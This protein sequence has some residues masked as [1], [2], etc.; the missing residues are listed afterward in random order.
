MSCDFI[1]ILSKYSEIS[2]SS[3]GKSREKVL[4]E[5]LSLL[6]SSPVEKQIENHSPENELIYCLCYVI[7]GVVKQVKNEKR[8]LTKEENDTIY[9]GLLDVVLNGLSES[10]PEYMNPRIVFHYENPP[11][12]SSVSCD[13]SPELIG[14]CVSAIEKIL[15]LDEFKTDQTMEIVYLHYI[16]ALVY[17]RENLLS[18]CEGIISK[19]KVMK[20]LLL[21]KSIQ[22]LPK[23]ISQVLHQELM[24]QLYESGGFHSLATNI[25]LTSETNSPLWKKCETL[26]RI[27]A[28]PGHGTNFYPFIVQ[29]VEACARDSLE[30]N[31]DNL[32]EAS[33]TCL[34][35]LHGA[36]VRGLREIVENV[37]IGD[38]LKLS[39]PEDTLTGVI[40]MDNNNLSSVLKLN[41]TAFS[42]SVSGAKSKILVKV[43]PLLF[44]LHAKF[45]DNS[46]PQEILQDLI[47]KCLSNRSDEEVSKLLEIFLFGEDH[48]NLCRLHPR[49][50]VRESSS[51]EF[52][53]QMG[54]EDNQNI[55]TV[56]NLTGILKKSN[57]NLLTY[58]IFRELLKLFQ[59]CLHEK[60]Q[61][62]KLDLLDPDDVTQVIQDTFQKR[63]IL[64]LTL[65]ELINFQPIHFLLKEHPQDIVPFVL[66]TIR[67]EANKNNSEEIDTEVIIIL[68]SIFRE[69]V[70]VEKVGTF[71]EELQKLLRK[72]RDKSSHDIQVYI[73][74][75]LCEILEEPRKFLEKSK[76]QEVRQL[77]DEKMPHVR[78]YGMSEMIKLIQQ[79]DVETMA[80]LHSTFHLALQYLTD[81]DSYSF[82][83]CIRLIVLLT[84]NLN[85]VAIDT[86]VHE[87][88]NP[89]KDMD[90]KLKIGEAIVKI[91]EGLGPVAY[92]YKEVLINCYL[93]G[94]KSLNNIFRTSAMYNLGTICRIL[95]YQI[96]NFFHEMLTT[97]HGILETDTY[98]PSR[99]AATLI[100]CQLLQ[101][102]ENLLDFQEHL[103]P[104]YRLLKQIKERE[105]D[106]PC[107]VHA[108][109]G[110][111]ILNEKVKQS[112]NPTESLEK[113]IKIFGIKDQKE[114]LKKG[115][116]LE[117]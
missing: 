19:E 99:R 85:E 28:S 59:A 108:E 88:E 114:P 47:V 37:F 1:Q 113:E 79:K 73:D 107:R 27:I 12:I 117:L 62:L 45:A 87:Y 38:F 20:Y 75:F 56:R 5:K 101:G 92:K 112:L 67:Q 103:L 89:D 54:S 96:H 105:L 81:E 33:I 29:E 61:K 84:M 63:T 46:K 44:E 23:E 86:L 82:L 14:I 43:L 10:L 9:L 35:A 7:H 6:K 109:N 42:G 94:A 39:N 16:A 26:A 18:K 65:S 34:N 80:N 13:S 48:P 36:K 60:Q 2:L 17:L 110:L 68:M 58:S 50:I 24:N 57:H 21:L 102:M 32:V 41:S 72:I 90:Y 83:T 52:F 40:L 4:E 71:K 100:L 106:D 30:K 93:R 55:D 64:I 53:I 77:C 74:L 97:I 78:V 66:E 111:K 31:Q 70:V 116:I 98:A 69:F 95:T 51:N 22:N 3:G 25:I 8:I 15:S 11:K 104:T 91:T 76:F 115:S 49:V